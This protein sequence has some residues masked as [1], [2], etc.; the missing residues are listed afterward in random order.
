ME[1]A[2]AADVERLR[3]AY[4]ET[5]GRPPRGSEMPAAHEV[6]RLL[7]LRADCLPQQPTQ[8]SS[9]QAAQGSPGRWTGHQRPGGL[10]LPPTSRSP[11]RRA[12]VRLGQCDEPGGIG[13]DAVGRGGASPSPSTIGV[14]LAEI[15]A[16]LAHL[17][18]AQYETALRGA[19]RRGLA[20]SPDALAQQL[21][22]DA[23][24]ADVG[25]RVFETSRFVQAYKQVRR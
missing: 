7:A 2:A 15:S 3:A 10:G 11:A 14:Q 20:H 21:L 4:V 22:S 12:P 18:L 13:L 9:L 23:W 16:L 19:V 24:H 25:M 5:R 17:G 6:Q 8:R 1:A